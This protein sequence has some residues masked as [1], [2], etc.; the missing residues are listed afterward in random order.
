M[1]TQTYN[2]R[3]QIY[4]VYTGM[5]LLGNDITNGYIDLPRTHGG[6]SEEKLVQYLN[7]GFAP[8]TWG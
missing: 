7:E 3:S 4:P 8:Y 6:E 2:E 5:N 1:E